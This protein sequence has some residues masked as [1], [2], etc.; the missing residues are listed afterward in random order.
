MASA[1]CAAS[2]LELDLA[3][4]VTATAHE[5]FERA[6]RD[7]LPEPALGGYLRWLYRPAR[8]IVIL[9]DDARSRLERAGVDPE[10]DDRG[11]NAPAAHGAELADLTTTFRR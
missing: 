5:R 8:A 11:E 3:A 9:D 4:I 2:C 7:L 6:V 1:R 10:P